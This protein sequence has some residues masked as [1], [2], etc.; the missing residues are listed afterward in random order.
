MSSFL[1]N[2]ITSSDVEANIL[3]ILVANKIYFPISKDGHPCNFNIKIKL[4]S[5]ISIE[6]ID[7]TEIRAE[8]YI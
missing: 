1:I 3:R 2:N 5:E 7:I 4:G 6:Y 8:D